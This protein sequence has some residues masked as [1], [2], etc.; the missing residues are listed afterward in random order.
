MNK[1]IAFGIGVALLIISITTYL[2][3]G[4]SS[5]KLSD[6]SKFAQY[7]SAYTAGVISRESTIKVRFVQ[8][9]QMGNQNKTP[10]DLDYFKFSPDIDGELYW[11]D[12]Q[13]IEFSP[14]NKLKPD[15]KL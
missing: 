6:E 2:L 5:V 1:K 8:S 10:I 3:S 4:M 15:T 11:L 7:I 13:T 9:Y 14:E 12:N